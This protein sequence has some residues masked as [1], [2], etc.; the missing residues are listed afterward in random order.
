[1]FHFKDNLFFGRLPNG[2]VRILKFAMSPAHFPQATQQQFDT[3]PSFD[4]TVDAN[5]WSSV[6][7]S[8]SA[9]GEEGGRFY[10]AKE[11][12]GGYVKPWDKSLPPGPRPDGTYPIQCDP[13]G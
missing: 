2:D 10:V 4:A 1:M 5:S 11:F 8:V 6:V 12:H 13:E 9:G 3:Q 7:A